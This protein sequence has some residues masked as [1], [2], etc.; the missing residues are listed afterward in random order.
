MAEDIVLNRIG[1]KIRKTCKEIVLDRYPEVAEKYYKGIVEHSSYG[2]VAVELPAESIRF[3]PLSEVP[4]ALDVM[5]KQFQRAVFSPVHSQAIPVASGDR[6]TYPCLD[7]EGDNQCCTVWQVYNFSGEGEASE[8]SECPG[9]SRPATEA[10]A[11]ATQSSSRKPRRKS[12][13]RR[14]QTEAKKEKELYG[15]LRSKGVEAERQVSTRAHRLDLWIPGKLMLELKAGKVSADDICQAL[16]YFATYDR[17]ILLVGT[18]LTNGAGRGLDAID[19]LDSGIDVT[20][21]TWNGVKDYL[22]AF[23]CLASAG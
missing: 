17:K 11:S 9:N 18:G 22:R 13:R 2:W 12:R 10:S 7:P 6:N 15:W 14:C 4:D 23:L 20:F 19:K 8:E 21:I 1:R 5:P 16:D 3:V